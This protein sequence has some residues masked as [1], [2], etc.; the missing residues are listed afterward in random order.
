MDFNW[1]DHHAPP[2]T[3]L[4]VVAEHMGNWISRDPDNVVYN[5]VDAN[6]ANAERTDTIFDICSNGFKVR[7]SH[8][9]GNSSSG[10]YIYLAFAE[11]P[12]KNARA[13]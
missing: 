5:M 8:Q 2:F 7:D 11:S 9:D 12:F 10:E 4:P 3:Y 6:R 1:H 13:R